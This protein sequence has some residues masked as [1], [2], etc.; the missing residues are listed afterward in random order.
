MSCM[1]VFTNFLGLQWFWEMHP[2]AEQAWVCMFKMS[3]LSPQWVPMRSTCECVWII[4]C[5]YLEVILSCQFLPVF[6]RQA[7]RLSCNV[8]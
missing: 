8:W 6:M 3:L 5:V 2:W 7:Q 1:I 4:I